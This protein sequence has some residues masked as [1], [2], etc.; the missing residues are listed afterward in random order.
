MCSALTPPSPEVPKTGPTIALMSQ[1]D[2][3]PHVTETLQLILLTKGSRVEE[4]REA[5]LGTLID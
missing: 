5:A 1:S 3:T 4:A 2:H